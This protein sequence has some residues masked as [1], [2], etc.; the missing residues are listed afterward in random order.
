M[1]LLDVYD[2]LERQIA[3]LSFGHPRSAILADPWHRVGKNPRAQSWEL[4]ARLSLVFTAW[5]RPNSV[6]GIAHTVHRYDRQCT[7]GAGPGGRDQSP[8]RLQ[9]KGQGVQMNPCA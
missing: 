5:G 9:D 6:G 8:W 4:L 1:C 3:L 7:A 2:A